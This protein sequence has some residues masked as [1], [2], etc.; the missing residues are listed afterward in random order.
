VPSSPG[1]FGLFEASV[2][3]ALAPFGVD[4][5]RAVSFAFAFHVG[6]YLPVTV[7]G[8]FYLGR[9]GLTWS[10]VGRSEEIVEETT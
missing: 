5:G 7:L 1:C 9:L 10:E 2:R 6:S 4:A 3:L 8:L